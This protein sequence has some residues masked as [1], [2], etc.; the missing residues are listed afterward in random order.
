[1]DDLIKKVYFGVQYREKKIDE[2]TSH[3]FEGRMGKFIVTKKN[4]KWVCECQESSKTML[5]C[6]HELLVCCKRGE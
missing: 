2:E 5:P 1:M 4:E 3:V 6:V